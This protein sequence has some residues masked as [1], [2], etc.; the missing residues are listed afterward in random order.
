MGASRPWQFVARN[1]KRGETGQLAEIF[2]IQ[3]NHNNLNSKFDSLAVYCWW[4][5]P[6]ELRARQYKYRDLECANYSEEASIWVQHELVYFELQVG[7]AQRLE[8]VNGMRHACLGHV[9]IH[10]P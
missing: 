10:L 8:C 4:R 1:Q 3:V 2:P 5:E 9:L 6:C 7:R